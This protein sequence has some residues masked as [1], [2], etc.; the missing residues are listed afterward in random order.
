MYSCIMV[1]QL[2]FR[3]TLHIYCFNNGYS[4]YLVVF[5]QIYRILPG[6]R[7]KLFHIEYLY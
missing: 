4:L 5:S 3:I 7:R 2:M 1:L 6:C